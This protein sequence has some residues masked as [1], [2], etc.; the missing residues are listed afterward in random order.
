MNIDTFALLNETTLSCLNETDEKKIIGTFTELA[1]RV[2]KADFGF[3]WMC[4]KDQE[5]ELV[6]QSKNLPYTPLPPTK[7]GRNT[8]VFKNLTPDFVSTIEKRKGK[9]DVSKYM[10][11]FVII[12]IMYQNNVYGTIVI[13]FKKTETFSKEKRVSCRMIG[14]NIAQV[15]TIFRNK[16][17]IKE[18]EEY[19]RKIR[20]EELRNEFLV[21]IMHEIRTPLTIIKGTVDL[22][23]RRIPAID[24]PTAFKSIAT[25]A[26]HLME[27]LSELSVLTAKDSSVQ[28]IIQTRKIQLVPFLRKIS[29]RWMVLVKK[30]KITIDIQQI[31]H[32][33]ILADES[34]LNK[35]FTNIVTNAI[36]YGKNN[37][38]ISL[39]GSREGHWVRIDIQDDGIGISDDEINHVF[40]RFYRADKS[41]SHRQNTPGT[42]LGLAITK[43]IAEAHGG[44]VAVS[45]ILGKGSTF[46][47]YLPSIDE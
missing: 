5:F 30:K 47:V 26:E 23:M 38:H 31:P 3:V 20:E 37:G 46:S 43:W 21:D 27:M 45:S 14:S 39:R 22:S 10:K 1:I 12:P 40:E 13:C 44:K 29:K 11:S 18:N 28:R 25:E 16:E 4:K 42:G 41:R 32:V 33:S 36:A 15:I 34:Y 17:I 7:G 24:A 6:Y 35:L 2:L 9:Y 8:K 19:R